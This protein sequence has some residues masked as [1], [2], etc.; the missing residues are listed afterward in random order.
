MVIPSADLSVHEQS[1]RLPTTLFLINLSA[2]ET[3]NQLLNFDIITPR[4]HTDSAL[5]IKHSRYHYQTPHNHGPHKDPQKMGFHAHLLAQ[6]LL[7][8]NINI[9]PS[10]PPHL[11]I[12]TIRRRPHPRH[13]RNPPPILRSAVTRESR[14]RAAQAHELDCVLFTAG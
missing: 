2:K 14:R 6:I 4:N 9:N 3:A 7:F 12:H 10:H 5:G 13:T 1:L 8:L 11:A